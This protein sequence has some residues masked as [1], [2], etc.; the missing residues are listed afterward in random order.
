MLGAIYCGKTPIDRIYFGGEIIFQAEI[1][2]PIVFHVIE[3]D[4]LMILG[5]YSVK[6]SPSGLYLDCAPDVEWIYPVQNGNVLTIEQ[7]Y[8]ATQNGNVLEVK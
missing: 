8:S 7:V 2:E 6:D 3:D 5:A 4:K 1:D